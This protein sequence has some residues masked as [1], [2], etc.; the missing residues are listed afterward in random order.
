MEK[1]LEDCA[2]IY[3]PAYIQDRVDYYCRFDSPRLLINPAAIGCLKRKEAASTY[4]YDSRDILRWF[5]PDNSWCHLWGDLRHTPPCPTVVKSR[6]LDCDN[7][8]SV[9][10]KLNRCRHYIFTNDHLTLEQKEDRALFRGHVGSRENRA[11][12]CQLYGNH[13]RVDAADTRSG[14]NHG[15]GNSAQS[16]PKMAI[17]EQ[18]LFR[19][20]LCLEGNDVASNLKW[21]MSSH[22]AAVMPPPTCETWFMEGRLKAGIH[23]VEIRPDF[24]DLI[25]KMDYYSSH[26]DE[27]KRITD[28]ANLYTDQFRDTRRERYIALLVMQKYFRLTK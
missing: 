23:Y 24:A 9:L 15:L 4:Y 6:P 8:N 21:V 12:F 10:L 3:D 27:L 17:S 18:L 19:Y 16:Q 28:A 22:S 1:E 7:S 13:P 14:A 26:L 5:K 25:E 11:V 2:A 20:I